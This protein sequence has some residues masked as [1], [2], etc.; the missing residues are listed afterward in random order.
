[1]LRLRP[2]LRLGLSRRRSLPLLLLMPLVELL[3]LLLFLLRSPLLYGR[4]RSHERRRLPRRLICLLFVSVTL[5]LA[6]A[7]IAICRLLAILWR[8]RVPVLRLRVSLLLECTRLRIRHLV[9]LGI[10]TIRWRELMEA[11]LILGF[12]SLIRPYRLRRPSHPHE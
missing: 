8:L 3:L 5:L 9:H 2:R 10:A 4:R 11:F 7:E 1:M 12:P 6:L